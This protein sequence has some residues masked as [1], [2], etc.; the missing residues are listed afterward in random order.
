V[1]LKRRL[2]TRQGAKRDYGS[3]GDTAVAPPRAWSQR[4]RDGIWR[5]GNTSVV[6]PPNKLTVN[7][8]DDGHAYRLLTV[9]TAR[10]LLVLA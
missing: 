9:A 2:K 7:L 4:E 6:F 10:F 5:A 3:V 1:A 8:P